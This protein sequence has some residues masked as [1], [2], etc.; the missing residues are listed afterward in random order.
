MFR[1]L[2]EQAERNAAAIATLRK[3]LVFRRERAD[4]GISELSPDVSECLVRI[5]RRE[6]PVPAFA[7]ACSHAQILL[8]TVLTDYG[9]KPARLCHESGA[10][11]R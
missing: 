9:C 1:S 11:D 7:R 5:L 6:A 4:I 8:M 3:V 10:S 2:V